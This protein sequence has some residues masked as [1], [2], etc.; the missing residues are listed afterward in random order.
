MIKK[1]LVFLLLL[2][3]VPLLF[4]TAPCRI[5]FQASGFKYANDTL[6]PTA[7]VS[8]Y[9][10][11]DPSGGI[12]VYSETW[13]TGLQ[14]GYVS[15][16]M[17]NDTTGN[18]LNLNWGQTYWLAVSI[19]G[20]PVEMLD[21][22]GVSSF[23]QAFTSTQGEI[24]QL[25][26]VNASVVAQSVRIDTLN[27]TIA[28]LNGT[29]I[30]ALYTNITNLQSS[31]GSIYTRVDTLNTSIQNLI[32]SNNSAYTRT[33]T[34]NLTIAYINGTQIPSLVPYT[35]ATNNV[36]LGN[37]NMT[38]SNYSVTGSPGYVGGNST[39]FWMN[40]NSTVGIRVGSACE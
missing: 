21:S 1:L 32:A 5:P 3:F 10:Y 30:P 17:G 4:A 26:E 18:P 11:V 31:N 13:A 7:S 16:T 38:A 8:T 24:V 23:R 39:C 15:V 40:F 14:D 33:N 29:L 35:G 22:Y 28:Y 6:I 34:L 37:Y 19:D 27:L 20:V 12:A 9:V 36:T 2:A 25:T